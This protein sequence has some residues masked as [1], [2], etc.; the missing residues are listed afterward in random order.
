[1]IT[2]TPPGQ[3]C[4]PDAERYDVEFDV[5]IEYDGPQLILF[6]LGKSASFGLFCET[7][8]QFDRWILSS[9][10]KLELETLAL[11]NLP[12]FD[13][14]GR[15][16]FIRVVDFDREWKPKHEWLVTPADVPRDILPESDVPLPDD[17]REFLCEKFGFS[18]VPRLAARLRLAGAFVHEHLIE[19]TGFAVISQLF[20]RVMTAIGESDGL[21]SLAPGDG[22]PSTTIMAGVPSGGS[23]GI[24]IHPH[25]PQVFNKVIK[26]YAELITAAYDDQ[27]QLESLLR[28]KQKLRMTLG[29]YFK[30]LGTHRAEAML[31]TPESRTYVGF[32]RAYSISTCLSGKS[33]TTG[34]QEPKTPK[35]KKTELRGYFDEFGVTGATFDFF[36]IDSD[37]SISGK[38]SKALIKSLINKREISVGRITRYR[39]TIARRRKTWILT[40][41]DELG[42][43]EF[44]F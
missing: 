17:C 3:S 12:M 19:F 11:G 41:V 26:R 5:L 30:A 7:G 16:D 2:W 32:S 33:G 9:V 31:E 13:L 21:L 24:D 14:F 20:Q 1:M 25:D 15:K 4:V 27:E 28:G 36:D 6:N 43:S 44:Q 18:T 23:F 8:D 34:S 35:A 38:V 37:E 22:I 40:E 10:T 29:A 39:A 42:Q